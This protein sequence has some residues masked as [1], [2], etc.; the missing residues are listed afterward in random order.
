MLNNNN[1]HT[2]TISP[3]YT[4]NDQSEPRGGER[5]ER[6][7]MNA[8]PERK[9]MMTEASEQAALCSS[10]LLAVLAD[11]IEAQKH[12]YH[13]A[14]SGLATHVFETIAKEIR[15]VAKEARSTANAELS[16]R[17]ANNQ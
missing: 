12:S 11:R 1:T 4:G 2:Q 9:R 17:C 5:D 16:D 8:T 7:E 3:T 15:A 14:H 6:T 10:D 13:L